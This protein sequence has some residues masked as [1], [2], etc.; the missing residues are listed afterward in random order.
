V[1]DLK[2]SAKMIRPANPSDA[3]AICRIYNPFVTESTVTFEENAVTDEEMQKR[4]ADV[5]TALPWLVLEEAG[6]VVAYAYATRWRVRSAYRFSVEST[7]YVDSGSH[8]RGFGRRLYLE[9][10]R[11][12]RALGL[13][14]VLG[15]IALPNPCSV[16]LHESLGFRKIAH[17]DEV[18]FKFGRWI[19][20]GY[21]ELSL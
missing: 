7:V 4:I 20:V 3:A 1:T 21:W 9:L 19:D 2:R 17:F 10:I 11:Q 14:R 8:R 16:G 18:G 12:L 5:S 13:H 15:G 6:V